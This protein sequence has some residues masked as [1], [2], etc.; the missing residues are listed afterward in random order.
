[1]TAETQ[2]PFW[3]GRLQFFDECWRE[4]GRQRGWTLPPKPERWRLLPVVRHVRFALASV[5]VARH[6][7]LWNSL[8]Y[9]STGYDEWVLYAI[10]RGW[11]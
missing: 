6:Y 10:R 4:M 7:A 5:Q 3:R 2:P 1:M 11:A 8:G 9:F